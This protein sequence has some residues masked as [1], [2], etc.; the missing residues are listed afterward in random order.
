MNDQTSE[1]LTALL[2]HLH[3]I[4]CFDGASLFT[5]EVYSLTGFQIRGDINKKGRLVFSLSSNSKDW[6]IL[7]GAYHSE[8][9]YQLPYKGSSDPSVISCYP[10]TGSDSL[11]D[12]APSTITRLLS[13]SEENGLEEDN[14]IPIFMMKIS[15]VAEGWKEQCER[16]VKNANL[17]KSI[18]DE[19]YDE[20]L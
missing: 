14:A 18:A 2:T 19:I 17:L 10:T 12:I 6:D 8:F 7:Q 1:K 3:I 5:D 16:L 13:L 9:G 11:D 15:E 20:I 4:P